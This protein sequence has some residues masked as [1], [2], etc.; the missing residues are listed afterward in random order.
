MLA[1][2]G[3]S[4]AIRKISS[5]IQFINSVG[6]INGIVNHLQV[7][8]IPSKTGS[9]SNGGV[10]ALNCNSKALSMS[11]AVVAEVMNLSDRQP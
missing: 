2:E 3:L 9:T 10:V 6:I 11:L 1:V 7:G 4:I 8:N 5:S